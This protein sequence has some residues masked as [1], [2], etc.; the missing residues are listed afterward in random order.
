M[1]SDALS[2]DCTL[3]TYVVY[4]EELNEALSL[5]NELT[6]PMWYTPALSLH[7][8]GLSSGKFVGIIGTR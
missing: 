3:N 5:V 1:L 6:L 4:P 8:G 7:S 2:M